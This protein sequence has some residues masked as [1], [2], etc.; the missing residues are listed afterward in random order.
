MNL[1]FEIFLGSQPRAVGKRTPRIPV[2]FSYE[3]RSSEKLFSPTK[4]GISN[5]DSDDDELAEI[6]KTLTEVSHRGGSPQVSLTPRRT[7]RV[8]FSGYKPSQFFL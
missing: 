3:N 6:A 4:Q 5:T 1:V 8:L 2:S 7:V